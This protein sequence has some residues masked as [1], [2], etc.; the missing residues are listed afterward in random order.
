MRVCCTANPH[1][2]EGPG[3]ARF[4]LASVELAFGAGVSQE[5]IVFVFYDLIALAYPVLEAG[6]VEDADSAPM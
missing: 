3:I 2:G 6:L 5:P 4:S 1:Q